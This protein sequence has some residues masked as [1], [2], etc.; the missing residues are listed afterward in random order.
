MDSFRAYRIYEQ[1]GEVQ[2]RLE[3]TELDTLSPGDVVIRAV[4]SDV[5]YKDALAG[6]GKGKILK[7]FPLIGGI[8]VAGKVHSS[9]DARFKEGDSVLVAGCG[10]SENHDGGFAEYARVP[11]DWVVPLPEGLSLRDSMAIGTAGFTAGI[12]VDRMEHNGQR[13]DGGP[14]LVNGATGGCR[15]LRHRPV[16]RARLPGNG[17]HRQARCR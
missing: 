2:G 6:T 10:L 16:C 11:G 13:P 1:D 14:I 15:Q 8:D 5:N 4:W 9:S 3:T 12:A 7:R 17:I